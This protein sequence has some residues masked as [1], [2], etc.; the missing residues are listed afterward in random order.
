MFFAENRR[1]I[2]ALTAS[3][4]YVK[5]YWRA[6]FSRLLSLAAALL[7]ATMVLNYITGGP[8]ALTVLLN[9]GMESEMPL[10][11]RLF[12]L[13][14][15]KFIVFP[16]SIIYPFGIYR[17]LREAKASVP[18]GSESDE[19]KIE[20]NIRIFS[21]I[22]VVALTVMILALVFLYMALGE[23]SGSDISPISFQVPASLMTASAAFSSTLDLLLLGR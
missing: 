1:G 14:F 19:Q 23:I 16:L 18:S 10:L 11:G 2:S 4:R 7:L 13:I 9:G 20:R 17:F 8:Q 21:M 12:N 22:G 3:W 5:G 15:S 6:T